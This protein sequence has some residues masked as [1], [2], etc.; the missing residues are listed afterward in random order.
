MKLSK[1]LEDYAEAIYLVKKR[2]GAVRVKDIAESLNVKLPSVT[3]AVKKL[4]KLNMVD[5]EKY[6]L[7]ELTKKGELAAKETHKKHELLFTFLTRI[8]GINKKT[9]VRD[10][11]LLEHHISK[12]TLEKLTKFVQANIVT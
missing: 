10:A 1:G 8:L 7:V 2:K 3:G 12:E 6:G 4:A 5:Y 11:C 9:A